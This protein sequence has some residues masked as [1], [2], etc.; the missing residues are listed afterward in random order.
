MTWLRPSPD[1]R[2]PPGGFVLAG[3]S[4]VAI[5]DAGLAI[6]FAVG[7]E[8]RATTLA[9]QIAYATGHLL[10][11]GFAVGLLAEAGARL[12]PERGW[13]RGVGAAVVAVATA[14]VILRED[15]SVFEEELRIQLTLGTALPFVVLA[16]FAPRIAQHPSSS[17]ASVALAT[18][19]AVTNA[20]VLEGGYAGLHL[21][22]TIAAGLLAACGLRGLVPALGARNRTAMVAWALAAVFA[23]ASVV[24]RPPNM[25]AVAL[26]RHP[27]ASV[28]AFLSRSRDS[29]PVAVQPIPDE[30]AEWFSD[31]SAV[32]PIPPTTPPLHERPIVIFL[33]IDALRAD[34]LLDEKQEATKHLRELA[35]DGAFFTNAHSV[36][37]GTSASLGAVFSGKYY[38]SLYWTATKLRQGKVKYFLRDED[39]VRWPELLD[40]V[41][42]MLV[43]RE[44][45]VDSSNGLVRGFE[46]T[47]AIISWADEIVDEVSAILGTEADG[48]LLVYSHLLDPHA[49]YTSRGKKADPFEGYLAEV[50][51]VDAQIGRLR[52]IVAEKGLE[53]RTFYVITADHG[54]AFGEHRTKHHATTIYEELVHVPLIVA[55]PKVARRRI[56]EPV[57]TMDLGPTILDLFGVATPGAFMGQS[58]VPL[59]RGDDVQLTRPIVI[60]T[61]RRKQALIG[62]DGIKVIRNL[63]ER[64]VE[65]Y[66]LRADPKELANL[67]D[68]RP[69]LLDERLGLLTAFFEAHELKKPGYVIPSRD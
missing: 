28:A 69:E 53:G 64:T 16:V 7:D 1:G 2:V 14:F 11:A 50:A 32:D 29:A 62:R 46:E 56:D 10:S 51:F 24:T 65:L 5:V 55:G 20:F 30:Q 45:G 8:L 54:E 59:L 12:L 35:D 48:P 66:D 9:W 52:S 38:S 41:T 60:D 25:V 67:A 63:T 15:Y 44:G 31:R 39:T 42:R 22:L 18:T 17:L 3:F 33:T 23:A 37:S 13:I 27:T 61:G 49:P 58:L 6:A 47:S 57:S 40:G 34:L 43:R 21:T 68:E 4:F 36:A 19:V 26:S